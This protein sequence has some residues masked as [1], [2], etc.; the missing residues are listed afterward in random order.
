MS[1]HTGLPTPLHYP[2]TPLGPTGTTGSSIP[3]FLG[4]VDLDTTPSTLPSLLST[5]IAQG[6]T[7]FLRNLG[8]SKVVNPSSPDT[9]DGA[10]TMTIPSTYTYQ[11]FADPKNGM[12]RV[13]DT[14]LLSQYN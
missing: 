8:G 1:L 10:S 13:Y 12:W 9:I 14:C 11:L 5:P 4:F 3:T 6:A 7:V 2:V